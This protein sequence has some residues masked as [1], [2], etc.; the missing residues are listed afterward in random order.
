[1][2]SEICFIVRQFSYAKC[3]TKLLKKIIFTNNFFKIYA[4]ITQMVLK[5]IS[6]HHLTQVFGSW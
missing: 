2:H 5:K 3:C 1:M 6:N 4:T